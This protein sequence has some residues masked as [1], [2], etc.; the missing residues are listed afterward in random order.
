MAPDF[1]IFLAV[2]FGAE[3]VA[4]VAGF[5]S[6]TILIPIATFFFDIKTAIALVGLFHFFGV[7]ADGVIWRKYIHW[8]IG[9]L[10]SVLGILFSFLGARL[11]FYL[12][13]DVVLRI[14]GIFLVSYSLSSLTGRE[15]RLPKNDLAVV[16][17]GGL[18]GFLAGLVGTAGALRTAFLSV[19]K[20]PKNEF[21]GTSFA[22]AFL[23]D[24]TRVSTYLGSGI[25]KPNLGTWTAVLGVA[26]LGSLVGRQFVFR[27]REKVF[28]RI[29]YAALFLAG[30]NF[31][32]T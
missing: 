32:L 8:R 7:V 27:I 25:L 17:A 22:I 24:L 5:G 1:L 31:L 11:V 15:L 3:V 21:L 14:L 2:A 13:A 12:P 23:V 4:T 10:F 26:V 16:G 18:V 28:Y 6:S 20:L 19:F 30:M 29:V 9:F